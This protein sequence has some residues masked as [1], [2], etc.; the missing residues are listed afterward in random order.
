MTLVS[1]LINHSPR[2][3]FGSNEVAPIDEQATGA[4]KAERKRKPRARSS[5]PSAQETDTG[6]A[7]SVRI[8]LHRVAHYQLRTR[9]QSAVQ[10]VPMSA[11]GGKADIAQTSTVGHRVDADQC[12]LLTRSGL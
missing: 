12:P 1:V 7:A 10:A 9:R 2:G 4:S 6:S 3:L 8:R 5:G 11:F